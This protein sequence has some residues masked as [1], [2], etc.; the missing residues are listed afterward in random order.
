MWKCK[1]KLQAPISGGELP[2]GWFNVASHEHCE[3]L[4]VTKKTWQRIKHTTPLLLWETRRRSLAQVAIGKT[5]YSKNYDSSHKVLIFK[6][7]CPWNTNYHSHHN[8]KK[9]IGRIA[10]KW[11]AFLKT[12]FHTPSPTT[13]WQQSYGFFCCMNFTIFIHIEIGPNISF[14]YR[15]QTFFNIYVNGL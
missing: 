10:H 8:R 7:E 3:Q 11:N 13:T 15:L 1:D 5:I 9:L 14:E 2:R 6:T 12:Y 4:I